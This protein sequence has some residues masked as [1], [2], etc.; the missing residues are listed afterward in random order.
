MKFCVN[1]KFCNKHE[2]P[3]HSKCKFKWK[4]PV[5]G[6]DIKHHMD[7]ECWA[8]RKM[9]CGSAAVGYEEG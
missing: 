3:Q 5:T 1:C 4:N 8:A 2:K 6:E 7:V 9:Y